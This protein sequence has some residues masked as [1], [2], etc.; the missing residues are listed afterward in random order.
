MPGMETQRSIFDFFL[1]KMEML[2]C[3]PINAFSNDTNAINIYVETFG[4]KPPLSNKPI[5]L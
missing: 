4:I 2:F 1:K 3:T 5:M